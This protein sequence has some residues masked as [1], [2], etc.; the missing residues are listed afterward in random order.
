M[1]LRRVPKNSSLVQVPD[2]YLSR[3][4]KYRAEA[5]LLTEERDALY[6]AVKRFKETI[7]ACDHLGDV[8]DFFN[9]CFKSVGF[10]WTVEDED[11]MADDEEDE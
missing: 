5:E 7:P 9:V 6:A 11:G 2:P 1:R 10:E 3:M 4:E 8:K